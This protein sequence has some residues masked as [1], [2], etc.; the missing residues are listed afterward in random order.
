MRR[1]AVVVLGVLLLAVGALYAVGLGV[2]GSHEEPGTPAPDA[3][4]RAVAEDA[5]AEVARA[6]EAIGAGD[7][8]QVLFGD[9]HVH[10]TFSFDAFMFNLPLQGQGAHPPADACDFARFCSALDFWSINDHAEALTD[11][12]WRETVESIRQCNARA[13]DPAH[14]DTVAFLGWEWTQ[15]GDT[16]DDHYGH[17]NVVMKHVDERVPERP[18]AATATVERARA[19]FPGPLQRGLLG[20]LA[21]E[22]RVQDFIRYVSE[23]DG[24]PLC[25]TGVDVRELPPDCLETAATPADLYRKLDQWGFPSLVIPHGTPWGFY[26][27]PGSSWDKQLRGAMHDPERQTL[28]EVYSGHGDSEPYRPWRAVEYDAAGN[29]VCPEPSDA[30]LPTCWR[31]GEIIRE[32][33][34]AAG[35]AEAECERRAVRARQLAAEAGQQAY[36]TVPGARAEDWLDAG[37]CR[38]CDEPAFN[39]R[40]GGS[41]QYIMA[42]SEFEESEQDGPAGGGGATPPPSPRPASD[43]EAGGPGAASEAP[44]RFRFGFIASSDN[45]SARPGTGF[46]ELNRVGF[47]ESGVDPGTTGLGRLVVPPDEDPAPRARPFDPD[48]T[49]LRGFQ[50]FEFERQASFFLTGGLVGLHAEGRDREAIWEALQRREV[51]GTS[52]PRILLWFELLNP[53]GTG[54]ASRPMGS[55]V[56]LA[57]APIFQ[58]RAVGSFEQ[59]PGCPDYAVRGLGPDEVERVCLGECWNPSDRRRRITR[60]EVVRI[61]PQQTPEES[62]AS[63]IDDPWKV[64]ACEPDPAGC[65]VTFADPEFP[66]AGR[67][68]L[69]YVRAYEEA[70]PGVNAGGVRCSRDAAGRCT[71]VD[72]C[73]GPAGIEDQ[74]LAP[75]E[76]RA[77]SS[78]IFVDWG[79]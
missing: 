79:G 16:P 27:P 43:A 60:I 10:S 64:F 23:R 56:A 22:P 39:Y 69:Y 57:Q 47:S 54:G 46:K 4:P 36:L 70:R 8:K 35:E 63:R 67:D 32:R 75:H 52:G 21:P 61:R 73:P 76:P 74:C 33:C 18:I 41:V 65:A 45:H 20:V 9:L 49:D 68:A 2:F 77:W 3:R 38:D 5:R 37:Q 13:G 72:L 58:A 50:L 26:T 78:P 11:R 66:E 51:Y 71:D 48:A 44:R 30:Y 25:P 12:H 7:A 34:L 1:V 40:P 55:E 53:P 28:I 24:V 6:A 17:K 62:I 59:L 42:L 15:V 14:P 29:A 31:A 19:A